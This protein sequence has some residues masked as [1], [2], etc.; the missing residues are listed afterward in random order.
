MLA[1]RYIMRKSNMLKMLKS[2][3]FTL[4]QSLIFESMDEAQ[5]KDP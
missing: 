4:G 2:L 1:K 5:K 3:F